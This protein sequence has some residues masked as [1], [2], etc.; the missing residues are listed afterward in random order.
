[1]RHSRQARQATSR[2]S[3]GKPSVINEFKGHGYL[4]IY[5]DMRIGVK[6]SNMWMFEESR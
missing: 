1:M 6:R 4:N 2:D 5:E 3:R